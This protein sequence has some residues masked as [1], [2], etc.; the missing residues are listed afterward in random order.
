MNEAYHWIERSTIVNGRHEEDEDEESQM[1][2]K[3]VTRKHSE[4]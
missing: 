2:K 3:Q 4:R 1:M